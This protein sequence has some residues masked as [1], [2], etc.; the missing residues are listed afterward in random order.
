[1]KLKVVNLGLHNMNSH[2]SF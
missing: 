1:M 2:Y